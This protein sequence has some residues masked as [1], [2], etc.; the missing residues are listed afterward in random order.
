MKKT[1]KSK[2][3]T[4]KVTGIVTETVFMEKEV[5]ITVPQNCSKEEIL[6]RIRDKAY[7]T[8]PITSPFEGWC[9]V[10]SLDHYVSIYPGESQANRD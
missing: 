3:K 8:T 5:T 7:R 2:A 6:N 1:K 9:P 10:F 4:K